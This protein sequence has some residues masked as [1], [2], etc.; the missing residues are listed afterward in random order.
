MEFVPLFILQILF[1]VIFLQMGDAIL[2]LVKSSTTNF[3]GV[4]LL[5]QMDFLK[6]VLSIF[7]SLEPEKDEN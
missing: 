2:G 5:T 6:M 4:S 3:A 7:L 1:R